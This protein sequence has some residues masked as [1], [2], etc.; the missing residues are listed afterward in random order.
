[1]IN[2]LRL[3]WDPIGFGAELPPDE[4]ASVTGPVATLLREGAPTD[5]IAETLSEYRV[6][7]LGLR[8]DPSADRRAADALRAWYQSAMV[9][10]EAGGFDGH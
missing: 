7:Q 8:P 5:Q 3:D 4:Y 1:M 9:H 2:V 6:M 10:A